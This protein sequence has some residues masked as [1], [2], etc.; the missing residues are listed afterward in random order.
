[1]KG[2]FLVMDK[3]VHRKIVTYQRLLEKPYWHLFEVAE[4][5]SGI[6]SLDMFAPLPPLLAGAFLL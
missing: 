2:F 5:V 1:M 4:Y 6:T 3:S